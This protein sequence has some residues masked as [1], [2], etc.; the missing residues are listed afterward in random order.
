MAG[1]AEALILTGWGEVSVSGLTSTFAIPRPLVRHSKNPEC[2]WH[3][4]RGHF[5]LGVESKWA[6]TA[7]IFQ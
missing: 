2:F 7:S 5:S 1:M 3:Y 4:S 6:N